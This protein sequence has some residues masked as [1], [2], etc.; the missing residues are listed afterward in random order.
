MEPEPRLDQSVAAQLTT[1]AHIHILSMQLKGITIS[2]EEAIEAVQCTYTEI[3]KR[4]ITQT[5]L[6]VLQDAKPEI[7]L[8]PTLLTE[9]HSNTTQLKIASPTESLT[10]QA[11]V[12]IQQETKVLSTG[13]LID[14]RYQILRRLGAGGM[15]AVYLGE[16]ID[17]RRKVA[18]KVMQSLSSARTEESL[19]FFRQEAEALARLNHPSIAQIY[20]ASVTGNNLYIAME[21]VDGESLR[22]KLRREVVLTLGEAVRILRDTCLGLEMAHRVGIIHRDIKPE[23]LMLMREE[24]GTVRVKILDFGLAIL[25]KKD[26]MNNVTGAGMITGTPSYMSPEQIRA[27]AVTPATDVYSLGVIGY[28]MLTGKNP[29][30]GTDVTQ[31]M[32]NHV[33]TAPPS[34]RSLMPNFPLELEEVIMRALEK[35]PNKRFSTAGEFAH[36]L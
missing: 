14:N 31:V 34:M 28:E 24:N 19:N 9:P 2:L 10:P 23:N 22:E 32:Y 11:A 25:D 18:I 5:I 12:Q 7:T 20:D 16:Q 36:A 8:V 29:F 3:L 1:A 15:G 30:E 21:Y 26:A 27:L 13:I 35:D 33:Y 4:G 6:P 17:T